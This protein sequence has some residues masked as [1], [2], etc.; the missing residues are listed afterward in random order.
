MGMQGSRSQLGRFSGR[1][2]ECATVFYF[3]KRGFTQPNIRASNPGWRATEKHSSSPLCTG[4]EAEGRPRLLAV[5]LIRCLLK[6]ETKRGARE[7]KGCSSIHPVPDSRPDMSSTPFHRKSHQQI[8]KEHFTFEEK[9][10]NLHAVS[11]NAKVKRREICL[12]L[13]RGK[14]SG[15]G[16]HYVSRCA[17]RGP[18]AT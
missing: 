6:R 4:P 2:D 16:G 1:V 18:A 5:P 10:G 8:L 13:S 11:S 14:G 17:R 3:N 9:A 12:S 15:R 7:S